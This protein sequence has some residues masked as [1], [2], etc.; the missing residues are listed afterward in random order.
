VNLD[1]LKKSTQAHKEKIRGVVP[2][3][4]KDDENGADFQ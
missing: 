3:R 2:Q 1:V 4:A